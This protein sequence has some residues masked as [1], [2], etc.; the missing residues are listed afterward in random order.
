MLLSTPISYQNV[1]AEGI[2]KL[3]LPRKNSCQTLK[4]CPRFNPD[5]SKYG[6]NRDSLELLL[7]C[8]SRVGFS[9]NYRPV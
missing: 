9:R 6:S 7:F 1:K 3:K 8:K 2:G 4:L 5:L